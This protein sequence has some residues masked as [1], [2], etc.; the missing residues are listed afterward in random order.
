MTNYSQ[1]EIKEIARLA[2]LH[3]SYS[4]YGFDNGLL[5][6]PNCYY[7]LFECGV[8]HGIVTDVVDWVQRDW[9]IIKSSKGIELHPR[10]N[11]VIEWGSYKATFER[12]IVAEKVLL[13]EGFD[14]K[15]RK[16]E[17]DA[18]ELIDLSDYTLI[19]SAKN[20]FELIS[21]IQRF[22]VRVG[23]GCTSV[24]IYPTGLPM[25]EFKASDRAG[26]INYI[27]SL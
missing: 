22:G 17:V 27:K 8:F 16:V 2:K 1:E 24:L 15:I 20:I 18:P 25:I 3:N 21:A 11:Y 10:Y 26:I 23:N 7:V 13:E 6:S 12:E 4:Q 9:Y 19:E 5:P 14:T